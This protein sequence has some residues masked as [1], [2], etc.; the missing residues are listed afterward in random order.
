M[1]TVTGFTIDDASS[2]D[3][4]DAIWVEAEGA[5]TRLQVH[6]ADVSRVIEKGAFLD[7]QALKRGETLYLPQSIKPMFPQSVEASLSLLPFVERPVVTVTMLLDAVGELLNVEI[8]ENSLVSQEKFSYEAVAGILSG[9]PHHLQPQLKL[10]EQVTQALMHQRQQ[11]GAIYGRTFGSVYVD[12]EGRLITQSVKAQP[13]I[14]ELMILTNRVVSQYMHD[15][16]QPWIYRTHNYRDLSALP[17]AR[18][19]FIR[20]LEAMNDDEQ[21]QRALANHYDRAAY[22]AVPG[23]HVGLGL[24]AYTHFTSPIRRYVDVVNHRLLKA[25]IA[26][27]PAPYTQVELET[28][29]DS[30]TARQRAIRDKKNEHHRALRHQDRDK[31]MATGKLDQL[32]ALAPAE[33]TRVLKTAVSKQQI[34]ALE[35]V[36]LQ[37]LNAET[38][39]PLDFYQVLIALPTTAANIQF[40]LQLW[41]AIADQPL[42]LQVINLCRDNWKP[43]TKV[44]FREQGEMNAWASLCVVTTEGL[45][46]CP[47]LWSVAQSKATARVQSAHQ[48]LESWLW[49]E[50]TTPEQ[51]QMPAP[52]PAAPHAQTP[53]QNRLDAEAK[54]DYI[55][56]IN[57]YAQKHGEPQAEYEFETVSSTH[58]KCKCYFLALVGE[59]EGSN[60][61]TAKSAAAGHLWKQL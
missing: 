29:A 46:Q 17:A 20:S 15:Q 41:Q 31:L 56:T 34:A 37:R 40:K 61:K 55:T 7:Q 44:E 39:Q 60:K 59:G 11:Q 28:I 12:E 50:L 58:F 4:D 54:T 45:E 24:D 26:G 36:I 49:E 14:A 48:W 13:I 8:A 2:Q 3:L 22:S 47:S 43:G 19:R 9:A 16:Q 32:E 27:S 1:E 5:Q 25:A 23:R 57:L 38:L 18:Q 10:L 21:L 30:L 6:I 33:F 53:K 52:E 35:A 51:A 42:T